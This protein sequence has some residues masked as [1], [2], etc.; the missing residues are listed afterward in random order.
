MA[1]INGRPFLSILL[2]SLANKNF[3]HIVLAVGYRADLIQSYFGS[4]FK[5][6]ELDYSIEHSPL[7]TGGA[8]KKALQLLKNDHFFLLNGDTYLDFDV[9]ALQA[10]WM[11]KHLPIIVCKE[12]DD[13]S[14]YGQ[15]LVANGKVTGFKE[16]A[17]RGGS[18]LINA[19]CLVLMKNGLMSN[20][21][22]NQF[23]FETEFL[24]SDIDRAE[25]QVAICNGT[26]I[27]IGIPTDYIRAQQL[28]KI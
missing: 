18:G 25:Y 26:F 1:P 3:K 10:Q 14:R 8:V 4:K 21:H 11:K 2:E 5:G 16:K 12:V 20:I 17:P 27:D 23:S 22:K 13:V 19:G 15:V 6:M 24:Y 9:E 28:I 7:G